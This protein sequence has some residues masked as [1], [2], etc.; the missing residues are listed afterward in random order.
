MVVMGYPEMDVISTSHIERL[1]GTTRLH[2]PL[3]SSDLCVQQNPGKLR[4]GGGVTLRVL[5]FRALAQDDQN[6]ASDGSRD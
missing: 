1:N 2:M 6:D 3:N 5:Q 4:G